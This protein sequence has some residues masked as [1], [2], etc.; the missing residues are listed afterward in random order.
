[1]RFVTTISTLALVLAPVAGL[2]QAPAENAG[3]TKD[4]PSIVDKAMETITGHSSS[5]GDDHA[6]R[7]EKDSAA[8]KAS[9]ANYPDWSKIKKTDK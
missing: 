2:A 3:N 7:S 4:Q 9:E 5:K 1:M 8:K 6:K